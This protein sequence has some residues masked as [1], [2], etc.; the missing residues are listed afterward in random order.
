MDRD[1]EKK[2]A[3]ALVATCIDAATG[4][5]PKQQAAM[6]CYIQLVSMVKA[7]SGFAMRSFDELLSYVMTAWRHDDE[8]DDNHRMLLSTKV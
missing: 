3:N 4:T 7:A 8:D 1:Y 2:K 5:A 6:K